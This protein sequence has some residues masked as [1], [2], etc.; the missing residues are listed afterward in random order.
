MALALIKDLIAQNQQP[1]LTP[2]APKMDTDAI[3]AQKKAQI[4][5]PV[6][7]M[8]TYFAAVP[9]EEIAK[10]LQAKVDEYYNYIVSANLVELWRRSYRAYYGMR[11][12]IGASG[13]GVFDVGDIKAAGDQGEITRIK[14]NHFANLITHQLSMVIGQR[15]AL[16]CRARNSDA[17]SLVSSLLGDGVVEYFMRERKIERNYFTAVETACITSEGYIVLGWNPK[18]GK[19]YGRGPNGSILYDGDL[20]AKNFT[21][22][23]V[24]KDV[25]KNS[26]DEQLWYITHS[27]INR[28]DLMARYPQLAPQLDQVSSDSTSMNYRTFADPSKIIAATSFGTQDNDDIPLMEFRHKKTD[29]VPQGRYT[30]F[31]NGDIK[32]FDGPLPFRDV[33]IYRVAPRNIIGTPFGWTP[34]FDILALQELLDKLY[35]IVSSNVLGSGVQNFWSPPNNN[36]QVSQLGGNRSLIESMVKPEV[37]QLLSTPAEVY[38]YINK[39]ESVMETLMGI[40]AINR[41]DLPTNDL[42]GSAMAFM[43]SQAINFNS[44]LGASANGLLESLGTGMVQIL[45]DFAATPRIAVI[46]GK[47]NRPMMKTYSGKDLEP[48]NNVVCDATSALSKTTAGKISIADNLLKA[49]MVKTPEEYLTLIKTGNME[50]MT[51]GPIMENFLIQQENEWLLE[52]K[53]VTALR[54]DAHAQHIE[55]HKTILGSPSARE[56]A[57]LVKNTLDHIRQHEIEAQWLQQNDPAF[58]A[59]TKQPPLP[60]PAPP[61]APQPPQPQAPGPMSTGAIP[62]VGATMNPTSPIAQKAGEVRGPNLPNLP[63]GSDPR[64]QANYEQLKA[65]GNPNG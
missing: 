50:P 56:D 55:E 19:E 59:A 46:S 9:S 12:N 22:F 1:D 37:L 60:F 49:N 3:I 44:Q 54:I 23:D 42:S 43:A 51:R 21:P 33:G 57:T 53:M 8:S 17:Q 63:K 65:Q 28:Y 14:V 36:V 29:A 41:G 64:T 40:S 38:N 47:Q 35:T 6:D 31:V 7:T 61:Q 2:A 11:Q 13:W 39:I 52:G 32:L 45:T 27:K 16:E 18:A 30:I 26:D 24:I 62:G 20:E 15:P 5:R 34:A 25:N 10:E 58:L 4:V 48:I